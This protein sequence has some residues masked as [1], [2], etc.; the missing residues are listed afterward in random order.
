MIRSPSDIAATTAKTM[1]FIAFMS[2]ICCWIV[3]F[4][5]VSGQ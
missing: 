4:D 3:I 5:W 2:V 1:G